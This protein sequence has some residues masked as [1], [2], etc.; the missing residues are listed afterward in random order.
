MKDIMPE[1]VSLHAGVVPISCKRGLTFRG[2]TTLICTHSSY[3]TI[4][5]FVISPPERAY[6][7][8]ELVKES[9]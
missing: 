5:Y 1:P 8:R 6:K 4:D 3:I 7:T 2:S 9:S